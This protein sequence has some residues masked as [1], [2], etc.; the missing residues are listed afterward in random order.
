M[1]DFDL[2]QLRKM[3]VVSASSFSFYISRNI[4]IHI[5]QLIKMPQKKI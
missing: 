3:S 4:L 1:Y 5:A 2:L